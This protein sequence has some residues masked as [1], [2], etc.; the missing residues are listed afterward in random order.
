MQV[1]D[2]HGVDIAAPDHSPQALGSEPEHFSGHR[3]G[4]RGSRDSLCRGREKRTM[5]ER[6][7]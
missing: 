6:E 7:M 4:L 2:F 5:C 1:P 3:Q